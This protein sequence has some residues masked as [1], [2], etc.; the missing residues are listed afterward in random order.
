MNAETLM[1]LAGR[2]EAAIG[3]DRELD[4]EIA[5][6]VGIVTEREGDLFFGHRDYSVMVL[7]R[8]YYDIEGSAPELPHLTASIDA[9]LMLRPQGWSYAEGS[10]GLT[11]TFGAWG[12]VWK[13]S[14][15]Q[16][17]PFEATAA[18]PALALTA[19]ALKARAQEG[20]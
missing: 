3:P 16:Y 7:E 1:E 11:K 4:A 18:T 5:L 9:A 2:V 17:R 15:R 8:G 13:P 14:N 20:K 10:G 19:A 12:R 6:A